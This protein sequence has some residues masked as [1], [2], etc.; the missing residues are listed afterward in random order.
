[1]HH[2]STVSKKSYMNSEIVELY[3]KNPIKFKRLIE[4]FRKTNG[5]LPTINRLLTLVLTHI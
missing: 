5:N 2:S 4:F 1:M 3:S